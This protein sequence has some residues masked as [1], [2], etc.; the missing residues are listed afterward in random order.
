MAAPVAN[1][2]TTFRA[3]RPQLLAQGGFSA[4][5]VGI[6][7]AGSIFS[8]FDPMPGGESFVVLQ[9]SDDQRLQSHVTLVTNW[10]EVLQ[11]TLPGS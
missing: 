9:G 2:E 7:V 4:D 5:Q 11:Q 3:G 1:D 8:D 10:F 6:M